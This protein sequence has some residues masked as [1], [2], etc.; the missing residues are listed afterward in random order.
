MHQLKNTQLIELKFRLHISTTVTWM[1]IGIHTHKQ[2]STA[3]RNM[4]KEVTFSFSRSG[5]SAFTT[6]ARSWSSRPSLVT[7]KL[8]RVHRACNFGEGS[9]SLVWCINW[10]EPLY[11]LSQS[12]VLRALWTDK[13]YCEKK[14]HS[15]LKIQSMRT[16]SVRKIISNNL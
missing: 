3:I 13:T 12:P 16:W 5:L 11:S 8:I 10:N 1:N 6:S 7:V 9:A 2:S 14:V 4:Y 15:L